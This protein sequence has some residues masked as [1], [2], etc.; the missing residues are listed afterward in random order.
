MRNR[1]S[2]RLVKTS[3]ET[4]AET[5]FCMIVSLWESDWKSKIRMDPRPISWLRVMFSGL[6]QA[7]A[8]S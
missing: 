3:E 8:H 5:V 4:D 6:R 7:V 1:S 2:R